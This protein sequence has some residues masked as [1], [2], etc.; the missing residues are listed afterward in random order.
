MKKPIILIVDDEPAFLDSLSTI[1]THEFDVRTAL[2][3]LEAL[4]IMDSVD[5]SLVLIDLQMP[6]M[7]GVE[8][9]Q[10]LRFFNN[11]TPVLVLTGNSSHEIAKECAN[12]DIQGYLEKPLHVDTLINR[13]RKVVG[14]VDRDI[15]Q[16]VLGSD[17]SVKIN[18]LSPT[19]R[20]VLEHVSQNYEREFNREEIA[21][22]FNITPSHLSRQFSK[23]CGIHLNDYINIYRVHR[24]KHLLKVTD[25]K[26]GDIASRV[27]I[28]D[29]NYFCRLFKKHTGLTPQEFRKK[30]L[31]I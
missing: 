9:I 16:S 23:E 15:L 6:G 26:I 2:N 20:R 22:L 24:C 28:S 30:E 27:G 13:I 19:I 11:K 7:G 14:R 3:C 17:Y 12:L 21:T 10:K 5:I 29:V 25:S 4:K 18:S 31:S 8:C 1:L